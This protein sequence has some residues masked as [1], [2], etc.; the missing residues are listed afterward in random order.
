M[1]KIKRLIA[2]GESREILRED[3]LTEACTPCLY[4]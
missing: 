1:V 3:G 4:L 2:K